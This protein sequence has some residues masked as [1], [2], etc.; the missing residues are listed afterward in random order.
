VR[1]PDLAGI[2]TRVLLIR[3]RYD[4]MVPFE[5]SIAILNHIADS[6]LAL[7]N[8][9]GHWPPCWSSEGPFDAGR[10]L[11]GRDYLVNLETRIGRP[12]RMVVPIRCSKS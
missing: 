2:R 1:P 5:V 10:R 8:N 12:A 9:C 3:G 7:L 6:R 11:R 4:R